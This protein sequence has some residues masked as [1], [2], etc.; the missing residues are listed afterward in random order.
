MFS[1]DMTGG[2]S[3][4][5]GLV[6]DEL[7]EMRRSVFLDPG[8]VVIFVLFVLFLHDAAKYISPKNK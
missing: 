5:N 1:L 2:T 7:I 3:V 8:E 6:R 4:K